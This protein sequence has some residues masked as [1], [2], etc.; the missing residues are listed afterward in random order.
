M[1]TSQRMSFET[2]RRPV[3]VETAANHGVSSEPTA[4]WDWAER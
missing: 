1:T 2:I 4:G 3:N